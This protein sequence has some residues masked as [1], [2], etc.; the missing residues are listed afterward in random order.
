MKSAIMKDPVARY[1]RVTV[2]LHW[3]VAILLTLLWLMGRLTG[4][5]PKGPLRLDIWSVHVLLGFTL[6]VLVV[7]RI[8][9][10]L[11]RGRRLPAADEGL[12]HIAA[13]VVQTALYALLLAVVALGI[14]NVFGHGFPLFG[15]WK[16]PRFWD[17]PTQ[18]AIN[19]WHD[20]AAN[21]IAGVALLHAAAALFHHYWLRDT[22]FARMLPS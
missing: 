22:V 15:E 4:F 17:K 20:L 1:D 16:F 14:A 2:N 19:E 11:T 8:A 21:I 3:G 10:R 6:A 9:W 12:R 5:L 18:H 13:V 7:A